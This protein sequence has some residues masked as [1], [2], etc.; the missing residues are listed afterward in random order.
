MKLKEIADFLEN[1]APLSLQEDYDNSGLLIGNKENEVKRALITLDVNEDVLD[2]AIEKKCD[3]IISHHPILFN[4]LKK[5]TGQN[6]VARI[7]Q[8]AIENRLSIYSIHTNLD[9]VFQNGVNQSMGEILT[10]KKMTVL[11]PKSNRLNKLIFY[12]PEDEVENI[13]KALHKAGAGNIGSYSHCSFRTVGKGVF[14]PND[15]ATPSIGTK[16]KMSSLDEMKVEVLIED[17]QINAIVDLLK[18][19]HPYEEVAYEV[20]PLRNENQEIGSG[21]IGELAEKMD[22]ISFLSFLKERLNL[23]SIKY[24]PYKKEIKKVAIVGGSG[25][26][27]LTI[28]KKRG[29]DAFITSDVKYHQFFDAEGEILFADIG[30]YESE[31]HTIDLLSN[32]IQTQFPKF[33]VLLSK[34]NTNPIKY[35]I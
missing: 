15:L 13:L 29:A 32:I 9:N 11:D 21:I 22:E 4:G 33:A 26:S 20:I 12:S 7:V 14:M 3:L 19:V 34:T 16:N 6:H 1:V 28:A 30:H 31:I 18:N 2:E 5:I 10:L 8:K 25:S 24:T 17:F 23:Q 35:F 27:W